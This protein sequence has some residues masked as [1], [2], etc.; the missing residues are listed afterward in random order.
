MQGRNFFTLLG[1]QKHW[2]IYDSQ[3]K[4]KRIIICACTRWLLGY[5]G[6]RCPQKMELEWL[7]QSLFRSKAAFSRCIVAC[8]SSSS[9]AGISSSNLGLQ[10]HSKIYDSQQNQMRIFIE[11]VRN[12]YLGTMEFVVQ[13]KW[14]LKGTVHLFSEVTPLS[15]DVLWYVAQQAQRCI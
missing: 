1:L 14:N 12:D 13:R 10:K 4:Q 3:Q 7:G 8:C 15:A 11:L 2:K 9:K 5:R 6:V